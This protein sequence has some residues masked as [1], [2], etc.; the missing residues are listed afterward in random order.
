MMLM[1][2]PNEWVQLIYM[3][4]TVKVQYCDK[5]FKL[6][7]GISSLPQVH[8]EMRRRYPKR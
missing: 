2:L 1:L 5:L 8:E 4:V 3:S 7:P 6:S